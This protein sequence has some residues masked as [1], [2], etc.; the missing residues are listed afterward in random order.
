MT[1]LGRRWMVSLILSVDA[2]LCAELWA[3]TK[4]QLR[5]RG[6]S[7]TARYSSC[8]KHQC[9]MGYNNASRGDNPFLIAMTTA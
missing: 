5:K 7:P 8:Y 3:V 4:N 6:T 2:P 1:S 9:G